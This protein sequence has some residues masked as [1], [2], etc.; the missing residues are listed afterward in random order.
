MTAAALTG[1]TSGALHAV[2]GPDHTL[3]L[4]PYSSVTRP[5]RA[6]QAGLL[7]GA[8]HAIGTLLLSAVL[9]LAVQHVDLAAVSSWGDRVA[10]LALIVMG[11]RGALARMPEVSEQGTQTTGPLMVGLVHGVTGAAA[12]V[13]MLPQLVHGSLTEQMVYLSGF[14]VGSTLAM[15]MLTGTLS[16]LAQRKLS[17]PKWQ[18]VTR[19]A[20]WGSV[21]LG[22]VLIAAA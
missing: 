16:L 7:W 12:L 22:A 17:S 18:R 15:G 14:A 11:L 21:V 1:I 6:L 4:M 9:M 5:K 20:G 10:G 19:G 8:G 3:S 13:L 2:A